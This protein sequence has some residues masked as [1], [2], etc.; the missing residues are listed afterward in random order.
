MD[1]TLR[2]HTLR[3]GVLERWKD[4]QEVIAQYVKDH[5]TESKLNKDL[6]KFGT[7]AL[8]IILALLGLIHGVNP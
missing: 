2:D 8:A 3:L 1:D 6:I 5:P 4:A 7:Y